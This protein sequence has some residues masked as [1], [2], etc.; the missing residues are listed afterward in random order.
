MASRVRR[1]EEEN[2]MSSYKENA[3]FV[4]NFLD[5]G[6]W[7]YDMR[8][9]ADSVLFTG[10]IAGFAGLYDSFRFFMFVEDD[11]VQNFAMFPAS[12][13]SRM[14]GVAE[15]ITRVNYNLKLGR[16][17]MDYGCGEVRF[18]MS[19]PMSA[20][21]EERDELLPRILYLPVQMLDRYARGFSEVILDLKTPEQAVKDCETEIGEA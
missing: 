11:L 16:F 18:H 2:G 15:F 13:R 7:R 5:E 12:A 17:E 10:G 20:V 6:N 4:K 9:H 14:S 8:E 19:L 3:E 21:R 1:K